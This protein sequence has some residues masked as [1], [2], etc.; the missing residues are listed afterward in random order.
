MRHPI[1]LIL[2]LCISLSY[3]FCG[4]IPSDS[5]NTGYG[6]ITILVWVN[7]SQSDVN[8]RET[9][10]SNLVV[11]ITAADMGTIHDTLDLITGQSFYSFTIEN[12]PAGDNRLVEAWTIDDESDTIH[13]IDSD[14]V[15]IEPAKISQVLLELIPIKG[16]I[17]AVLTD[18]P[19]IIDSV[20]FTFATT[21]NTW[22][23]KAEREPK[24]NICLDKIPFG[25]TGTLSIVGY[26]TLND[27]VASW[28]MENFTFTNSNVTIEASFISVG[29][30][31]IHVT[32]HMP[33]VTIIIGIMDTTDSIGDENGGL[34]ITE[35]MYSANDSEYVEIYNPTVNTFDETIIL[36]KDNG[37][38]RF[39]KIQIPP[40]DFYVIG[41]R[42]TTVLVDTVPWFDTTFSITSAFNLSSTTGNWITLRLAKDSSVIDNVAFQTGSNEQEWPN[43]STSLK[44]SIVLDSLSEDPEYNN[45]GR[46]WIKAESPID[47][48]ITQQLGTPGLPGSQ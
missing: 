28:K 17:Y 33:G 38:F 32:I 7:K 26:D 9:T 11:K 21:N 23:E 48:S 43:F 35:I 29:K 15:D 2:I 18:I 47:I 8:T 34:I 27:T 14:I 42:D 19:T 36:Q 30:I 44:A 4:T 46:N 1:S 24:L 10:W 20:E 37:T 25:T 3:F 12:V 5:D 41:R 13:G 16:S 45:F 22:K 31:E 40:K 39:F 6:S